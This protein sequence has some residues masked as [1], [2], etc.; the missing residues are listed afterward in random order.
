MR[1]ELAELAITTL[2]SR[3]FDQDTERAKLAARQGSV[4]IHQR[5]TTGDRS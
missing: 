5:S 2:L 3:E 1:R 4:F